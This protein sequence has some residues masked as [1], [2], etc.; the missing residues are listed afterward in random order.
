MKTVA[1]KTP[2]NW[3]SLSP[4]PLSELIEFGK[5]ISV[6]A[7]AEHMKA[8]GYDPEEAIILFEGMILDGRHRTAACK[9]AGIVPTFRE[10]RGVNACA[11]VA[12]KLMRQY[13]SVADRARMAATYAGLTP[14]N[15]KLKGPIMPN[16]TIGQTTPGSDGS[17][18]ISEAA[19]TFG[20]GKRSVARAKSELPILCDRCER[21]GTPVAGC[22]ACVAAR[23]GKA[24]GAGGRSH[25]TKRPPR[26]KRPGEELFD[27]RKFD[28]AY[29]VVA[30]GI[31]LMPEAYKLTGTEV[32]GLVRLMREVRALWESLRKQALK[33]KPKEKA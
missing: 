7:M 22:A 11:Y 21:I 33:V 16:G 17:M 25:P 23:K 31:R 8:H 3:E 14:G 27:W 12:K 5:G 6:E 1:I 32:E 18:T 2:K 20:V 13:P 24:L 15:P 4:H 9:L 28:A 26:K 10:F 29:G 30:R 19:K